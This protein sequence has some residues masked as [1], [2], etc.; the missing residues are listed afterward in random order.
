M[1]LVTNWFTRVWGYCSLLSFQ[2]PIHWLRSDKEKRYVVVYFIVLS[3]L[4]VIWKKDCESKGDVTRDNSQL[5]FLAQHIERKSAYDLV[6]IKNRSRKQ[7]H[8]R[9]GIGVGRLWTFLLSSDFALR[10]ISSIRRSVS[11]PDETP[12][13]ELKTGRA[14]EYFWWTSRCCASDFLL[15]SQ[16]FIWWWNTV[17]NAWYYFSNKMILEGEIKNAKLSSFSSDF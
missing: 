11:S 16:C 17:S 7:S 14:A 6:E 9:D 10:N 15:S 5:R 2:P 1:K 4:L 3:L 12:R 13:R 8:Q